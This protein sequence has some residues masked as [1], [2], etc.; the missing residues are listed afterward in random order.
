MFWLG[1]KA[2]LPI[3]N[4]EHIREILSNKF[5]HFG[6]INFRPEVRNLIGESVA[7]LEGEKWAQHR[8]IVSPAF[9]AERVK[10]CF[11]WGNFLY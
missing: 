7:S 6:K 8:R 11:L 3:R 10:V 9:F 5:G 1:F 2:V 4:P